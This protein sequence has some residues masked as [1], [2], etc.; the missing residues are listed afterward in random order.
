M[1]IHLV[2]HA[3]THDELE[4]EVRALIRQDPMGELETLVH[5]EVNGIEFQASVGGYA[6][7]Q[8]EARLTLYAEQIDSTRAAKKGKKR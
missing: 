1:E 4:R 3:A 2:V 8:H 6:A 7:Q 5:L